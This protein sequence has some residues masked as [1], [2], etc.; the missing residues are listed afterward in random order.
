M[1]HDELKI[2]LAI[3]KKARESLVDDFKSENIEIY[4]AMFRYEENKKLMQISIDKYF[5]SWLD[6]HFNIFDKLPNT[7]VS[8]NLIKQFMRQMF[9][10]ISKNETLNKNN[11]VIFIELLKEKKEILDALLSVANKAD[12][13][14]K[15]LVYIYQ[16]DNALFN[17]ELLRL[18]REKR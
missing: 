4:E 5:M 14:Y 17:R 2:L 13:N 15:K 11:D 6:S 8:D 1:S 16:K 7:I 9:A 18:D 12:A 3:F 10:L